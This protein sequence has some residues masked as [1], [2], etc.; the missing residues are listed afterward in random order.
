MPT[1]KEWVKD[2]FFPKFCVACQN[3][4]GEWLC[5]KCFQKIAAPQPFFCLDQTDETASDLNGATALFNY[6]E[7]TISQL[8]KLL[9]YN[10]LTDI[11]DI[12]A[13]FIKKEDFNF[14]WRGFTIIPVPLHPRRE[15]ERGFNQSE[16]IAKIFAEKL[17]LEIN[18]GLRRG[19]YTAQQAKLSKEE[20][21]Q[22]LKD[23][24]SFVKE[25]KTI[26]EKVLLV[27]DVFTTGATMRECAKVLK[28][29]GVK[30][31]CGLVLASG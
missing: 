28:S 19:V 3:A 27:D 12:F 9:K 2:M 23:A 13:K 31:V 11:A 30:I 24:F 4:E 22:N 14:N 6:G 8:I 21:Q 15:R 10:Y 17:G 5:E 1:A 20:R 26:P 7:N 29:N 25:Q 16:I 18:I